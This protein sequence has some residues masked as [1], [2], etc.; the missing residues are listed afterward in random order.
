MDIGKLT[1]M[2]VDMYVITGIPSCK[3]FKKAGTLSNYYMH[4]R[5]I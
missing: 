2:S 3:V 4:R 5:W 1:Y